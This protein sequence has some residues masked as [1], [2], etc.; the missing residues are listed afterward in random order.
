MSA[1]YFAARL[2][3]VVLVAAVVIALVFAWKAK[4]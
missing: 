1:R 3:D 2:L 4:P